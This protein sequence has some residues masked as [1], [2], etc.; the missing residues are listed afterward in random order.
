MVSGYPVNSARRS[1][2]SSPGNPVSLV[3]QRGIDRQ[4][5]EPPG[6]A[7]ETALLLGH[8][9]GVPETRQIFAGVVG[10]IA[11]RRDQ[12]VPRAL[13]IAAVDRRIEIDEMPTGIAGRLQRD[14]D[15]T[16]LLKA[17]A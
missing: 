17:Q 9:E 7:A 14:P 10:G 4:T 12:K 15:I 16:W 5:Q 13:L 11:E 6:R 1:F 2:P 3:P 8:L